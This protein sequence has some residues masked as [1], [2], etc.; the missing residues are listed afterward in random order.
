MTPRFVQVA[1]RAALIAGCHRS[2]PFPDEFR[3]EYLL[4]TEY[5][6]DSGS[7]CSDPGRTGSCEGHAVAHSR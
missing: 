2:L 6:A 4:P 7:D 1:L 5:R 3:T